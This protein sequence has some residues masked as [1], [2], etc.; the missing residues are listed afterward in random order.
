ESRDEVRAPQGTAYT[1][2][3][4]VPRLS[5]SATGSVVLVAL[6]SLT[7]EPDAAPLDSVVDAVT[8]DGDVVE[9]RWAEDGTT[10]RIGFEPVTVTHG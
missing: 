1:P 3:A 2:W 4:V 10:T 7:A 5:S 6:A 9:V 8:V